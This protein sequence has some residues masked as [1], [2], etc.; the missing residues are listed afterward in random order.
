MSLLVVGVSHRGTPLSLLER[1]VLDSDQATKLLDD[2]VGSPVVREGMVLSTCNRV[3]I[4]A[5][6]EK[7]H[8]ALTLISELL[9]RHGNVN[10]DEI[11]GHVYVHYDDRAVQHLFAVAAG[12]DSMLIGEHQVVGQVRDAF[13]LAQ[14]RGYAGRDL[15]AIVQDALHAARR[16][17]AETRIDSAGQTLVDVG[18]QILSDRLGPLAGRRALVIGAGAMASVAAAALTR[19]GIT[20]L[21]VAS[22]TLRRATALAQRYN[23]QAAALEKLADLLA[24]TD[25][26]VSC[27]GSVHPVVDAA[28]LTK[29]VAGRTD[30]L[31]ILDIALPHDV[32]PDVDR[33]PNVI[34]VDLETLRPVLENTAGSADVRHARQ[35]LDE[36]FD[37]HVARR[38]AVGVV[39]TVVALRDK[40]ARV[41]AAELRRLEKR[42][43]EL[44]PR[45]FEEIRTTV[46][47]VVD[48]LLH[49]PTVRVQELAGLAGPDSYSEALRTLFDLDPA[50]P[51][52][53]SAPQPSTDSPAR[54]AY[55][56]TDEA[57]TDAEPRRD[58]AEPPSAAAAQDAGRESRP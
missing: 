50:Q 48:K 40:A 58:D 16:V 30:P 54:A 15:H 20:G 34:R 32:D 3:E 55:Q 31:G 27:T 4:Y 42:L 21:T 46:H 47:R 12:L 28:T 17:R 52:A 51:V 9:S 2:L 26:V 7:F 43:P 14:E 19:V 37:A 49:A 1:A 44:D 6:V 33:L 22:R 53:I 8:P 45:Q 25:V 36:E 56:A 23:G 11:A 24:E 18:L 35:I 39:P 13:R 38:T 5:C 10:F 57:A 41:V 29:A